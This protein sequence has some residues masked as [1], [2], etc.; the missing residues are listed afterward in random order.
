MF[1]FHQRS[2]V[3]HA[4]HPTCFSCY[5]QGISLKADTT[6]GHPW[7]NQQQREFMCAVNWC[8]TSSLSA[9]AHFDVFVMSRRSFMYFA[10]HLLFPVMVPLRWRQ[11]HRGITNHHFCSH[12]VSEA[13]WREKEKKRS[14]AA[15]PTLSLSH[16][17]SLPLFLCIKSCL[18]ACEYGWGREG[19]LRAV[20]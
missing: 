5:S 7:Q 11:T 12:Y 19:R 9:T 1:S 6:V 13:R 15:H 3:R 18:G 4:C 14:L 8:C 20:I 16:S 2:E 10:W 17:V